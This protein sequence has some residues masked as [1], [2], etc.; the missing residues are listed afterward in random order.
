M[1]AQCAAECTCRSPVQHE[2]CW[3]C[4]GAFH[5]FVFGAEN[6]TRIVPSERSNVV[7][8]NVDKM[9]CRC[10]EALRSHTQNRIVV[11]LSLRAFSQPMSGPYVLTGRFFFVEQ[12]GAPS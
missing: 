6:D 1:G 12:C 4:R 2:I 10:E 7:E 3:E 8:K 5:A 11:D 9:I